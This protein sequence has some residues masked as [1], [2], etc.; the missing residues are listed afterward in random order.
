MLEMADALVAGAGQQGRRLSVEDALTLAHD[1]LTVGVRTQTIRDQI[2]SQVT[3]RQKGITLRPGTRGTEK[4]D[5]PPRDRAEL[6]QRTA[7]RLARA[8]S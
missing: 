3:T 2:R 6:Q 7:D 4:K 8:F 1:S 5:G